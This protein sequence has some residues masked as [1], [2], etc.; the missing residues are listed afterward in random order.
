VAP[1]L[2]VTH[3]RPEAILGLLG[4]LHTGAATVGLGYT[5]HGGTLS[6]HGMAFVNRCSWAHCLRETARLLHLSDAELLSEDE[7]RALDGKRRP[8][9]VI[10]PQVVEEVVH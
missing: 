1:R 8:H 4:P 6:T 9:G 5:N 2:F 7:R 3:T 10:I